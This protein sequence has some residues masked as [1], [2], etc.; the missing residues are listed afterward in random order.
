MGS[1]WWDRDVRWL[2]VGHTESETAVMHSGRG[3]QQ[4]VGSVNFVVLELKS[5]LSNEGSPQIS[6]EIIM[7]SSKYYTQSGN[8][9]KS[10]KEGQIPGAIGKLLK[11][12]ALEWGWKTGPGLTCEWVERTHPDEAAACADVPSGDEDGLVQKWQAGHSV[13]SRGCEG[14]HGNKAGVDERSASNDLWTTSNP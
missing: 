11:E 6:P 7:A 1:D 8:N 12:A 2:Q 13:K 4:K 5:S 14:I 9:Q 10:P 3:V